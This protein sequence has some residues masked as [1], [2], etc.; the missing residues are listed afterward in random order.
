MAG[1]GGD[2]GIADIARSLRIPLNPA[3]FQRPFH[4][5]KPFGFGRAHPQPRRVSLKRQ[6]DPRGQTATAT[7][8]QHIGC[9]DPLGVRVLGN[10][11]T[12]GALTCDHLWLVKGFDQRQPAFR[13]QPVTDGVAVFGGAVIGHDLGAQG[14]GVRQFQRRRVRWHD[15]DRRHPVLRCCKGDALRVVAG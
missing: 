8:D 12:H 9:F 3:A 4:I 11:Q 7:A 2:D 15:D 1:G 10:F 14:T 13:R 6:R 5:V